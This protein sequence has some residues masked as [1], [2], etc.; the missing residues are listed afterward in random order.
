MK[1]CII[2]P[3][4][5]VVVLLVI[6]SFFDLRIA[7]SIYNPQNHFSEFFAVAGMAPQ[8]G[9]QLMSPAMLFAVLFEKRRTMKAPIVAAILAALL[10]AG[11]ALLY[12]TVR[13]VL[14]ETRAPAP[15]L[16][17][18][19]CF[20]MFLFFL[21]A[22][23]FAK[24]NPDG[25]L[26]TALT[27]LV[28]FTLGYAVLQALKTAWGRQRFCTM[29]NAAEQFTKW[30]IP[31]GGGYSDDFKSFPSGHSFAA[32]CAIWFALWPC[33]IDGLK[34]YTG[35]IL[36]AAL[37]FGF[38]VMASRMICGRH[39]LSDVTVGAAICTA[40]F[41]LAKKLVCR[42]LVDFRINTQRIPMNG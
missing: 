28:A 16:I 18:V 39:F 12:V 24:K 13:D 6:A 32:M 29:D 20:V 21:A 31:R 41:A 11:A 42:R 40:S 35:L 38:A 8:I 19:T 27:G 9:I 22:L 37:L 14:K 3:L 7:V 26:V 15:V 34:K 36:T 25:L 23:P 10:L 4:A 1:K 2:V 30:Y 33:F 17:A 5:V